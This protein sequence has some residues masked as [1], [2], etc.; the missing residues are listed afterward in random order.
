MSIA[1]AVTWRKGRANPFRFERWCA[2]VLS[3]MLVLLAA[4]PQAWSGSPRVIAISLVNGKANS[5]ALAETAGR[6]PVLRLR[7][8]EVVELHWS[9]DHSM[10]LHLHG[11]GLEVQ[12]APSLAGVMSFAARLAGRFP[13]ETHDAQG[14]HSPVLYLEVH[15]R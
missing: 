5:P 14:R 1:P 7:Q 13:V 3:A 12:T 11:Y 9:S 10:A 2:L 15:P 6:A 8:G 4:I